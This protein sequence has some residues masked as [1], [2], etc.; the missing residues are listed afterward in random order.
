MPYTLNGIG[1]HYYG[2]RDVTQREGVCQTCG[3]AGQLLSYDTRL[4][5]VILFIPVIPLKRL[6]IIDMCPSCH[7]HYAVNPEE[8][9]SNRQLQ[10]SEGLTKYRTAPTVDGALDTHA[11][12]LAFHMEKEADAFRAAALVA[13]PN[14]PELLRGL[15]SQLQQFSRY[16][17]AQ[18]L[19][20]QAF[21]I[22]P[23]N[24]YGRTQRA[25][26]LLNEPGK[27]DEVW[28]LVEF[29]RQPG[30]GQIYDLTILDLLAQKYQAEGNHERALELLQHLLTEFPSAAEQHEVRKM[31]A[32]SEKALGRST[33][34]LP[35]RQFSL[36]AVL[37]SKSGKY[38]PWIRRTVYAAIATSLLLLGLT[39]LN[40]YYRRN[41]TL[42]VVSAF[43]QPVQVSIDDAPPQEVFQ[44]RAFP[45]P[46]GRH[47]IRVTGPVDEQAEIVMTTPF[48]ERWTHDPV[49]TYNVAGAAFVIRGDLEYASVPRPARSTP[50]EGQFQ[51][52]PHVDYPFVTPPRTLRID[53]RNSV[54]KKVSVELESVPAAVYL[55][56]LARQAPPEVALTY[57][58]GHLLRT[59]NYQDL[60]DIYF[61]V[62][63]GEHDQ[64]AES[65]LRAGLWTN[66]LSIEWHRTYQRLSQ[67]QTNPQPL[68]GEYERRLR[69]NPRDARILYLLARL[70][71]PPD[72][73]RLLRE[74]HEIDP[75]LG[76]PSLGLGFHEISN[77]HWDEAGRWLTLA[78]DRLLDNTLVLMGQH[79]LA[80]ATGDFAREEQVLR[81]MMT[82]SQRRQG[83][84]AAIW[85]AESLAKRGEYD[86]ATRAFHQFEGQF[87]SPGDPV[88]SRSE[89]SLLIDYF[90]R[91]FPAAPPAEAE[92]KAIDY[93]FRLAQGDLSRLPNPPDILELGDSWI[94]PGSIALACHLAGQDEA[95]KL[96]LA[97]TLA[98]MHLEAPLDNK[99]AMQC[100]ERD[101]PP[102]EAELH[103]VNGLT[104]REKALWCLLLSRRFPSERERLVSLARKLHVERFPPALLLDRVLAAPSTP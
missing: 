104:P 39:G 79:W 51:F 25:M 16:E 17:T 45:L 2:S 18:G 78:G 75:A 61:A 97:T 103:Q 72:D 96:W 86:E 41:R 76:W 90:C 64:R 4:W 85:L 22:D 48:F 7:H 20:D 65:F 13:H 11:R 74:A 14:E 55:P 46:E 94:L 66:P 60:L 59:P 9:E 26:H 40:E 35:Q 29:L 38:P 82:H 15:A 100:L 87:R 57:A 77:A 24:P 1:T 99:T 81:S 93:H 73:V 50:L 47:R 32:V 83:Y 67:V 19:F 6:R 62:C 52:V 33:S 89:A 27:L 10:V 92:F 63:S 3:H 69:D 71:P 70:T 44:R 31:V 91:R 30:A 42:H 28:N 34:I 80:L 101:R 84:L 36:K 37:D 98:A 54:V 56:M 88:Q 23:E 95:W 8:W 5:F 49:W 58:E 43:A 12:M 53:N 102:T 68:I 21:E